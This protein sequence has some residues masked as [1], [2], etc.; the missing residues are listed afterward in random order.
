[1][2]TPVKKYEQQKRNFLQ[3]SCG[4]P[5]KRIVLQN[6]TNSV[7]MVIPFASVERFIKC[8]PYV[9]HHFL[10][11]NIQL[12]EAE[13]HPNRL[14][15]FFKDLSNGNFKKSLVSSWNA[16]EKKL[17]IFLCYMIY[18]KLFFFYMFLVYFAQDLL[19][20]IMASQN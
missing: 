16:V 15:P 14:D 9:R 2:L 3:K 10:R 12:Y 6:K 4:P 8:L 18:N 7:A 11:N 20:Q 17:L 19:T 5:P 13:T 1:M